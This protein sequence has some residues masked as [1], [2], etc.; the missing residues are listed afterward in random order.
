MSW[1]RLSIALPAKVNVRKCAATYLPTVHATCDLPPS[2]IALSILPK[3]W[4]NGMDHGRADTR[5]GDDSDRSHI[6]GT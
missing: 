6:F 5:S 3:T 1:C 4:S 2:Q